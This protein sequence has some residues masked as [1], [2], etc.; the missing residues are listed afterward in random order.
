MVEFE[1]GDCGSL[2]I[3]FEVADVTR[4]LVA[5]GELQRRGDGATWKLRDSRSGNEAARQ[6]SGLGAFKRCILHASDERR[7]RHEDNCPCRPGGLPCPLRR[8]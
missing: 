3:N 8:T 2:N 5:V 4:P 1:H 7:K 6:L